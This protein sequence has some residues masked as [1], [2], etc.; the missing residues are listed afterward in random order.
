MG[1]GIPEEDRLHVFDWF[2]SGAKP[3]HGR[4]QGS[5]LGLAIVRDLVH[6]HGGSVDIIQSS[7]PG[8]R[9]QV[10]LPLAVS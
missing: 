1:P 3:H 8:A 6:A 7:E 5:G 4:V 10:R 2:F 9:F